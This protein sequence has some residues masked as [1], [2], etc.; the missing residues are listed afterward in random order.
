MSQTLDLAYLQPKTR[1]FVELLLITVI[2]HGQRAWRTKR[3]ERVLMETF[4]KV[5]ETPQV[6][7]GLQYFLMK[8][9]SKTDVAG[10]RAEGET[11]RWACRVAGDALAAI[12][13]ATVTDG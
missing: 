8:V 6:A 11:V 5:R 10:G 9:V 7:R 13:S 12:A 1:L 4:L 3:E 2:L